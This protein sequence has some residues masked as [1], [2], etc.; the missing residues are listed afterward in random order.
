M[1]EDRILLFPNYSS[2][3]RFEE[4]KSKLDK[5]NNWYSWPNDWMLVQTWKSLKGEKYS[6]EMV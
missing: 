3:Y 4:I 6:L 5:V 2:F 1:L